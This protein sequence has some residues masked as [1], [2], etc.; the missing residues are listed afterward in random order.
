[1]SDERNQL[2]RLLE[3]TLFASKEPVDERALAARLPEEADIRGLLGDLAG[4]YANRG[5]N[6]VRVGPCWAFRTAPDLAPALKVEQQVQRRLSRAA[7]ETLAIIAY[8][9][10]VTRA[11]I[12]DIRG[13]SQ[14]KGTLDGGGRA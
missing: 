2:I 5:V 8:H 11:E 1:M 14:S 7:V 4:L 12:E 13:V 6:L 10:P 9:Q 3:A